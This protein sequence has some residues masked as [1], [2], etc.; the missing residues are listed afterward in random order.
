[1][2]F[3]KKRLR[4]AVEAFDYPKRFKRFAKDLRN[5]YHDLRGKSYN[6]KSSLNIQ[7]SARHQVGNT[8]FHRAYPSI[9]VRG[10]YVRKYR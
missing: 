4:E 6:T 5:L 8:G 1:M 3:L 10:S 7:S 9:G 2:S